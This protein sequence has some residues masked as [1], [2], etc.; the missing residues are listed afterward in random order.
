MDEY[1][2][3]NSGNDQKI[4]V[5]DFIKAFDEDY[6]GTFNDTNNIKVKLN[7]SNPKELEEFYYIKV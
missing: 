2:K 1:E 6:K 5:S 4:F 7:L 3:N